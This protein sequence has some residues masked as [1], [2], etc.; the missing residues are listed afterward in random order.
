MHSCLVTIRQIITLN[1]FIAGFYVITFYMCIHNTCNLKLT[2]RNILHT[3]T[4][5][6]TPLFK[7]FSLPI[8]CFQSSLKGIGCFFTYKNASFSVIIQL[9]D[10][11]IEPAGQYGIICTKAHGVLQRSIPF[12]ESANIHQSH[13]IYMY[14]VCFTEVEETLNM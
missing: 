7:V 3:H 13:G 12:I 1:V 5:S 14:C 2:K 4:S 9:I 11:L 8:G 6:P 10:L